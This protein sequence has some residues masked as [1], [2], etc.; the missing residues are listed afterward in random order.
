[1]TF[2]EMVLY[3]LVYHN[4]VKGLIIK[5]VSGRICFF[6]SRFIQEYIS[7]RNSSMNKMIV[8][9]FLCMIIFV[10]AG[11][12]SLVQWRQSKPEKPVTAPEPTVPNETTAVAVGAHPLKS[13]GYLSEG[14]TVRMD[15]GDGRS[16]VS[17]IE[18]FDQTRREGVFFQEKIDALEK[19]LANE[20]A[21]GVA[22]EKELE[23]FK[24]QQKVIG[25]ITQ[26][27]VE[28]RKQL[29]E[30][31]APYEKK[32]ADLSMELTKAQIGETKA[33]QELI[34]LKIESLIE[35]KKQKSPDE[36]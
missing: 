31:Q 20:K 18:Q 25:Q 30:V 33:K 21:K 15:M 35:K 6:C 13:S 27:N 10:T 16:N 22:L 17:M 14:A 24:E 26:E 4:K 8:W 36:Q 7:G 2:L 32:I 1:M 23:T 11:C 5:H 19:T 3:L 12:E 34:S 28:L 9:G 29:E